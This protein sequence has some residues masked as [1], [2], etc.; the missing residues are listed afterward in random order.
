MSSCDRNAFPVSRYHSPAEKRA[1]SQLNQTVLHDFVWV[2]D[3]VRVW[4]LATRPLLFLC[5]PIRDT[6]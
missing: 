1:L 6:G 2:M 3:L 5:I 4:G